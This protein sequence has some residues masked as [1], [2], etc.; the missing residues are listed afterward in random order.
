MEIKN[1]RLGDEE[2]FKERKE[3]LAQW[4]TGKEVDL[5]E[6]IG[7]LKSLPPSKNYA[8][9]LAWAKETGTSLIRSDSGVPSLEEQIEYVKYLQDEGGSD[10]LGTMVD[11]FTRTQRYEAA[12]RELKESLRLGKWLLNGVPVVNYG[13]ANLRKIVEAVDLPVAVRGISL[14]WRMIIEVGLAGGH[15]DTSSSP[16]MAFWHYSRTAPLEKS[17]HNHQ[18]CYRL[19]GC[20]E[21]AGVPISA[22][23]GG[24]YSILCPYSVIHAA[25]ILDAL[26]AA[27]QG[28]KNIHLIIQ[29][30]GH[31]AQDVAAA[32]T[33]PKLGQYYMDRLGY[34]DMVIT[35][36]TNSWSGKFPVDA[37]EAFAVLCMGV[38]ASVIAR[39]QIAHV[40]TIDE[41]VTIPSREGNAASLRAGKKVINIL[42]DQNI[43]LDNKAVSIEAEMLE[44]ETRA[45]VD[46]VIELGDGDVAVGAVR[47]VESGVLDNPF[48][49]TQYVAGKIMG[50]RDNEG[51][52]R[53]MAH[54][55]LPFTKEIVEFHKE[56]IAEREKAQGRKV[57]YGTVVNDL[58]SMSAGSLV[59]RC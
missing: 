42:K 30:Q 12:E 58:F 27:E 20:Y 9:K 7:Y 28:T 48:A 32:M 2:F 59:V 31:M 24:G 17:I 54:G 43:Q 36:D 38:V 37:A 11:S 6:A 53:Y 49:T 44:M 21:E 26:M 18:Y 39:A 50:V 46:R 15:T 22:S 13:V 23:I 35:S 57:D 16:M 10:L 55:N 3:V 8:L 47:A 52:V 45:I 25:S 56:K 4:P 29:F 1:K 33:L 14:D 51:A 41:G 34:K 19:V 40:K 5:D